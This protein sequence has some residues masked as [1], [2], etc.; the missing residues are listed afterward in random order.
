MVGYRKAVER[1]PRLMLKTIVL[2]GKAINYEL[3]RKKV[4]NLNLRIRKD[5]SIYVSA[6]KA[7]SMAY[8]ESFLRSNSA[9]IMNVLRR[10]QQEAQQFDLGH[11]EMLP[12]CG[13]YLPVIISN[14]SRNEVGIDNDKL[15]LSLKSHED[16][17]LRRKTLEAFY[18]RQTEAIMPDICQNLYPH[19]N[20]LG[21]KFPQIRYRRMKRTWGS[22]MP[23][24]STVT[25]NSILSISDIECMEFVAAHEFCHFL[26][27]DHSKAFYA[28]LSS[29]M[30]D[31]KDRKK[32]LSAFSG[33]L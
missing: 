5:G 23:K 28:C 17:G 3:Q 1:G 13:K 27:P 29:V 33:W 30:P 22:C 26:H 6:P 8:I 4:K 24:K 15:V 16:S 11:S 12:L 25:F 32:R 14:G 20:K 18:R 31:W 9:Y 21:I 7:L 2:E 10:T 19:F